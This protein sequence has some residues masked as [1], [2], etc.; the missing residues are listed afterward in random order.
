MSRPVHVA[1]GGLLVDASGKR[2][3]RQVGVVGEGL[4]EVAVNAESFEGRR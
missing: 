1:D 4:F 2:E 3:V